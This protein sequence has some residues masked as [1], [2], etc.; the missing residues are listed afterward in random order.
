MPLLRHYV[1]VITPY[2]PITRRRRRHAAT[3]GSAI[4]ICLL[5]C[6]IRLH[7]PVTTLLY[8]TIMLSYMIRWLTCHYERRLWPRLATTERCRHAELPPLI[9]DIATPSRHYC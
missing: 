6:I 5:V 1:D 8:D 2:Q 7:T 4:N 9:N 3:A